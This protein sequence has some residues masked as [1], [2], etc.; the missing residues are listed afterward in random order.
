[1]K[2]ITG[3][4]IFTSLVLLSI[5]SCKTSETIH[6]D[7]DGAHWFY[8]GNT[9]PD[10]WKD[11]CSGYANCGHQR[12]SPVNISGAVSNESLSA[13]NFNYNNTRVEIENNGHTIEFVCDPG[14]TLHI[15]GT[16]YELLQFHYHGLSEHQLNGIYHPLEVHF[17]HK[18][19]A[20]DYAV[21]G[22]FYDEG[23]AN[24]LFSSFLEHFPTEVGTY[25][26]HSDE[27]DH[28]TLLPDNKS[29]FHY[30]GSLTPPPCSEVVDWY[31][32]QHTVSASEA[33]INAFQAILNNNY[34]PIQELN[35][36][37]IDE[38]NE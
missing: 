14:S 38:F 2:S 23:D 20:D 31:V 24:P 19:T 34:R 28:S 25:E 5:T 21:M 3:F 1:M 16:T 18:A 32:L 26:D 11:L 6:D 12:Q 30:S 9:G 22:I 15:N 27:I 36:R 10:H 4:L 7:C 35:G 33:Q 17:I 8:S 37:V 29:Y 13:I